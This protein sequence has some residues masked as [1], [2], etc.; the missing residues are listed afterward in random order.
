MWLWEKSVVFYFFIYLSKILKLNLNVL[1]F[2]YFRVRE[3][4][5]VVEMVRK[6]YVLLVFIFFR[7]FYL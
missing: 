5:R 1:K 4:L 6:D 3:V 2:V 7:L